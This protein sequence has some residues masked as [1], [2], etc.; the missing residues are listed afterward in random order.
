M[1]PSVAWINEGVR[2]CKKLR[3]T[4]YELRLTKSE[5]VNPQSEIE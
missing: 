5:T 3:I 1:K 2:D 4:I